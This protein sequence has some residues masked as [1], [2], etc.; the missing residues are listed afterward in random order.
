MNTS[1]SI[2]NSLSNLYEVDENESVLRFFEYPLDTNSYAIL[3]ELNQS[4]DNLGTL[5]ISDEL[6]SEVIDINDIYKSEFDGV[7]ATVKIVKQSRPYLWFVSPTGFNSY[8]KGESPLENINTINLPFL[9]ESFSTNHIRFTVEFEDLKDVQND[10]LS[11]I[12]YVKP[13]TIESQKLLPKD[14]NSWITS[15]KNISNIPFQSW[16]FHSSLRLLCSICSEVFA[17][18]DKVELYFRGERRKKYCFEISD[19]AFYENTF[20]IVTLSS[21][22]IFNQS[23][24]IDTRHS[25]FNQQVS[26]LLSDSSTESDFSSVLTAALDNSKLAYRYHL[27]SSSKDLTK[28]LTDLNKTLFEYISKIRQN[29]T[30]LMSAVWRDFSTVLGLM[31]L[32][33]SI[34]KPDLPIEIFNYLA[35]ALCIYLVA[36]I[37]LTARISFW[38]Y[39][40]L[41][42]NLSDWK[43]KIYGYLSDNEFQQYAYSPLKSAQSKYKT[44]FYIALTLYIIMIGAILYFTYF[45]ELKK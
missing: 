38:Y 21:D 5:S 41:K 4:L 1:F 22:W 11:V 2:L 37:S 23:K 19:S 20:E 24:D 35:V 26:I 33:F 6:M 30:D 9:K 16:K 25:I 13:L 10:T 3:K 31:L 8:L 18:K 12:K 45:F 17:E 27:Q 32:N 43:D 7:V 44:T 28:T 15:E 39:N 14:V 34:K 42:E 36:S 29:T 40:N